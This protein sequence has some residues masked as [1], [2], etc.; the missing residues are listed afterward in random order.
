M[1]LTV[2]SVAAQ[3]KL[4][5]RLQ[6]QAGLPLRGCMTIEARVSAQGERLAKSFSDSPDVFINLDSAIAWQVAQKVP[7][8]ASQ[9][10]ALRPSSVPISNTTSSSPF[11]EW[12]VT[13][14]LK[15]FGQNHIEQGKVSYTSHINALIKRRKILPLR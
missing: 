8:A 5:R 15:K 10:V 1:A 2:L 6:K 12:T 13:D 11:A 14:L 9:H 4:K 3:K 7:Q